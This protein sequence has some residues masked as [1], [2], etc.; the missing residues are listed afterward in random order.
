MKP[1]V[2][3]WCKNKGYTIIRVR[4]GRYEFPDCDKCDSINDPTTPANQY[5]QHLKEKIIEFIN[6]PYKEHEKEEVKAL[7]A[8]YDAGI[9]YDY[10]KRENLDRKKDD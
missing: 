5:R 2:C 4:C 6:E 1:N 8:I 3:P 9:F 10:I 7:K